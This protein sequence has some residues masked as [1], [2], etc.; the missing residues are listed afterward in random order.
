ME[1]TIV[2]K[3]NTKTIAVLKKMVLAKE[4]CRKVVLTKIEKKE[5]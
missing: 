3:P 2:I 1:Q 5:K 4:E